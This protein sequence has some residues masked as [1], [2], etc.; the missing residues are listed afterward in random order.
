MNSLLHL[1]ILASLGMFDYKDYSIELGLLVHGLPITYLIANFINRITC[2]I[3]IQSDE[4]DEFLI[5]TG[6]KDYNFKYERKI[7]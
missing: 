2:T 6:A 3:D 5:L 7:K 4:I 1:G